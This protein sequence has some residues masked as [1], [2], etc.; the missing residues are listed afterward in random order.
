MGFG[1]LDCTRLAVFAGQWK[2]VGRLCIAQS[3]TGEKIKQDWSQK[4][5]AVP[6]TSGFNEILTTDQAIAFLEGIRNSS[7]LVMS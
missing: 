5:A 1:L 6:S 7:L 2:P 3:G 4:Q